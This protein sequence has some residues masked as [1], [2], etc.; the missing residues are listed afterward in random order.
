M[1]LLFHP[2]K[3]LY[4]ESIINEKLDND[5][6]WKLPVCCIQ[7]SNGFALNPANSYTGAY[8]KSQLIGRNTER[9]VCKSRYDHSINYKTWISSC[10]IYNSGARSHRSLTLR[11]EI[12]SMLFATFMH[13]FEE[14]TLFI[15]IYFAFFFLIHYII[16][17]F[18][19]Y[20]FWTQCMM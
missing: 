2:L 3:Y 17:M 4:F 7:L 14:Y 12:L 1:T 20:L 18:I 16:F 13:Y 10:D 9:H 11:C 15:D 8:S 6:K 19:L 5:I